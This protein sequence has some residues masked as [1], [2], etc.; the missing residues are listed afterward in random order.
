V[1]VAALFDLLASDG[2]LPAHDFGAYFLSG[3]VTVSAASSVAVIFAF[4]ARF[5]RGQFTTSGRTKLAAP[6]FFLSTA[7]GQASLAWAVLK[8]RPVINTG[9]NQGEVPWVTLGTHAVMAVSIA[10]TLAF[11]IRDV[12]LTLRDA[13]D[14]GA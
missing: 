3:L 8:Q 12:W 6:G 9:A 7:V 10:L 11:L 2:L 1:T 14:E 13:E 4:M 5:A